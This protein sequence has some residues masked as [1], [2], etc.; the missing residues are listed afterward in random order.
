[1]LRNLPPIFADL[2]SAA[3]GGVKPYHYQSWLAEQ[4]LPDVLRMP[5]GTGKTLAATLP[6]LYRRAAHPDLEVG[7]LPR[8]G[9]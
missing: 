2:V 6:W 3:T 9:W 1:M 5:T 4:G 7:A 8:A